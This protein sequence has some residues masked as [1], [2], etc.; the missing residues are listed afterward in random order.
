MESSLLEGV[1]MGL[2]L[3]VIVGPV[4]FT[5][6][7]NSL[8]HGFRYAMVLA[9]GILCSD[10]LYVLLTYFGVKLLAD[11]SLF[12][13][14]LGYVGGLILIGFGLKSLLKKRVER[15]NTGGLSF[16]NLSKKTAFAK[17]F[18]VNG[19]NPFVLL[20]WISIASLVSLKVNWTKG[21]V[22]AYY[23]GIL[24]TVFCID[25]LKAFIAK[26]LS[27]FVTPRVMGILNKTVGLLIIF[28]GVRMIYLTWIK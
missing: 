15:P 7:T 26:Q 27:R 12:E 11:V 13:K 20:F 4:F 10:T 3:S 28:Y 17:G 14:I 24:V 6:I 19:V 5:L 2:L 25:L 8:Q 9:L 21:N 1:S 22:F 23:S 16:S 18:G